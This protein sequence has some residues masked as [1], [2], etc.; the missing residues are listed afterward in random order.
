M[1]TKEKQPKSRVW[2]SEMKYRDIKKMAIERGMPFPGVVNGD[3]YRL[4]SFIDSDKAQKPDPS[5]VLKFDLWLEQL[6]KERGSDY[7]IKPSLRISY[8][9]D[10]MREEKKE[11]PKEKKVR[12][13]KPP[14]ERDERNLIKGTKKSYTFELANKGLSIERIKR[15]VLKRFPDASPKSIVIWYRKALDLTHKPKEKKEHKRNPK[16]N[17]KS[18]EELAL[19][20]ARAKELREERRLARLEAQRRTEEAREREKKLKRKNGKKRKKK[21]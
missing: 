20:K 5:L 17:K 1:A 21:I 16:R 10:E 2:Y 3:F 12:E 9:S 6:L 19:Q 14:K 7:L 13:K 15:R 11:K 8:V 4:I 18:P